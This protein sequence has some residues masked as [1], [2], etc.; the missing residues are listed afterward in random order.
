MQTPFLYHYTDK[1]G[2]NALRAQ[3]TWNF[4][5]DQPPRKEN[6]V[7]AYFTT[8]NPLT[9]LLAAKLR[10]GRE[11]IEYVFEFTDAGDLKRLDPDRKLHVFI[12]ECDYKVEPQ[13]QNFHGPSAEWRK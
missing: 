9:P 2:Y 4:K 12:S 1:I 5:T 10:I 13:R 6:P 11:K 7:A 3:T 8:L